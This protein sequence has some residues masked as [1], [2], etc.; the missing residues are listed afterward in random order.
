M[1]KGIL[2]VSFPE[3]CIGCELCVFAALRLQGKV[4]LAT[5][6]IRI[7][8]S[9]KGFSIHLDPAVNDLDAKQ[10]AKICPKGCFTLEE[11]SEESSLNFSLKEE[12]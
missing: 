1:A 5:S 8:S 7:M 10:I 6:P 3:K 2:K 12:E 11:D 4:G 9:D